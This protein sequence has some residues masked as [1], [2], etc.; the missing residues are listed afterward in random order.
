MKND[1]KVLEAFEAVLH[2]TALGD[3][4]E[5]KLT[6]REHQIAS[7]TKRAVQIRLAAMRRELLPEA[8]P[9]QK[10]KPLPRSL[11]GLGRD[12]LIAKL[13]VLTTAMGG[14]VQYAHR[15]LA[16]LTDDDL[17]QLLA[18]LDKTSHDTE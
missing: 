2:E 6:S 9:I 15:D 18:L 16:G 8:D 14:A 7:R 17:R 4:E 13:E 5:R 12:A 11:L 1:K 3:A 10:A